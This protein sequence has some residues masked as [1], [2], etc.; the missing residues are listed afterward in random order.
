M[1]FIREK[2]AYPPI[3]LKI[4]HASEIS[5]GYKVFPMDSFRQFWKLSKTA[6]A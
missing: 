1:Q 2:N 6:N 5:L 3:D 4:H